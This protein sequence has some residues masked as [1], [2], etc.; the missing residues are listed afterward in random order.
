MEKCTSWI[1]QDFSVIFEHI[2]KFL[3]SNSLV[4]LSSNWSYSLFSDSS[5]GLIYSLNLKLKAKKFVYR[6]SLT[7]PLKFTAWTSD[8]MIFLC[9]ERIWRRCANIHKWYIIFSKKKILVL[10]ILICNISILWVFSILGSLDWSRHKAT[11]RRLKRKIQ[12]F[13]N[14]SRVLCW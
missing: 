1:K 11:W 6:Y 3:A 5:S 8:F 13:G 12:L 14:F 7:L 4:N 10:I 2:W 9:G